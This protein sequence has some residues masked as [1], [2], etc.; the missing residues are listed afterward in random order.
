MQHPASELRRMILPRTRVNKGQ[1]RAEGTTGSRGTLLTWS[2]SERWQS[3]LMR[4]LLESR[5]AG[6]TASGVR[7]PPLSASPSVALALYFRLRSADKGELRRISLP[8]TRVDRERRRAE[9]L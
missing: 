2:I 1:G 3:G 7:I 8:R 6:D 4:R 9:V 5:H